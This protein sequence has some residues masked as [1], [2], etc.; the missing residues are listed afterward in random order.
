MTAV[1]GEPLGFDLGEP[2][3]VPDG[4]WDALDRAVR[5]MPALEDDDDVDE[6]PFV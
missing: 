4:Y 6:E 2:D 3:D 5:A 1:L